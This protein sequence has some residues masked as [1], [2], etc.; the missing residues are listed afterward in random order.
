LHL[1]GGADLLADLTHAAVKAGIGVVA[2]VR[3]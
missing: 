3:K 2:V 1:E